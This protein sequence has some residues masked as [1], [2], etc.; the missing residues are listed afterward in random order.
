M[1]LL[2]KPATEA[3]FKSKHTESRLSS[4]WDAQYTKTTP[5]GR[6]GSLMHQARGDHRRLNPRNKQ[7]RGER[8]G[9]AQGSVLSSD[10]RTVE[11][12][13]HYKGRLRRGLMEGGE[14]R[15]F[16]ISQSGGIKG[17]RGREG[18]CHSHYEWV[19]G[20]LCPPPPIKFT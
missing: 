9:K 13:D 3:G 12:P 15:A 20:S 7:L 10:S 19:G 14:K 11:L 2:S 16:I 4:R 18:I 1:C 5:N 8:V 17:V 6:P